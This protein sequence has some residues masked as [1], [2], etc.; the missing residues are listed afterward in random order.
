[1]SIEFFP[2]PSQ[3]IIRVEDGTTSFG[4]PSENQERPKTKQ[5]QLTPLPIVSWCSPLGGLS[6]ANDRGLRPPQ[7]LFP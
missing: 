3:N 5:W 6:I 2:N 7:H 1:M 4:T